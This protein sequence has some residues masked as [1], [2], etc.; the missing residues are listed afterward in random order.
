[1]VYYTYKI[2]KH[3]EDG[4][5]LFGVVEYDYNGECYGSYSRHANEI[6]AIIMTY[7]MNAWQKTSNYDMA[8][9]A[10]AKYILKNGL[11]PINVNI[12]Y[13]DNATGQYDAGAMWNYLWENANG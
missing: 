8:S 5:A 6:D 12:K 11:R 9:I 3:D 1:M 10:T 4:Q 13:F 7:F 2:E